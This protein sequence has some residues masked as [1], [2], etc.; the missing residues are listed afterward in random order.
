VSWLD[1]SPVERLDTA[2]TIRA[3]IAAEHSVEHWADAVVGMIERG[4]GWR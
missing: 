3:K 1:R 2:T 4:L